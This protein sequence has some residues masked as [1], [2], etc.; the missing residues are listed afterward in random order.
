MFDSLL[1]D[2]GKLRRVPMA[3]SNAGLINEKDLQGFYKN[4]HSLTAVESQGFEHIKEFAF[5]LE[6]FI[7]ETRHNA[8]K[9]T[10]T[11]PQ[12]LAQALDVLEKLIVRRKEFRPPP[13]RLRQVAIIESDQHTQLLLKL[14]VFRLGAKAYC[15]SDERKAESF[16]SN[17]PMD[18]LVLGADFLSTS[19]KSV[20]QR[21]RE[22]SVNSDTPLVLVAGE[23]SLA[24]KLRC[25]TEGA[26]FTL[27]KPFSVLEFAVRVCLI[28]LSPA[29]SKEAAC[30]ACR[31]SNETSHDACACNMKQA[32]SGNR[33][34]ARDFISN[35]L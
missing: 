8:D 10:R 19:E 22:S 12:T 16:L 18:L 26:S 25:L 20:C 24:L 7:L 28:L 33:F 29:I 31:F 15:F 2:L 4:I 11:S 1:E 3:L 32:S 35:T 6:A 17:Q 30:V 23:D 14:A 9:A 34:A 13:N 5:L 21:V 27:T